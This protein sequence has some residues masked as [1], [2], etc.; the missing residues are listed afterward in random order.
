M[1]KNTDILRRL[2]KKNFNV[3]NSDEESLKDFMKAYEDEFEDGR[4]ESRFDKTTRG[5]EDIKYALGGV[6]S[7][8]ESLIEPWAKVDEAATKF[9]RTIGTTSAMMKKMRDQAIESVDKNKLAINYGLKAMDLIEAQEKYIKG[10]GRNV[11]LDENAQIIAGSISKII[12]DT[13]YELAAA[14]E[15]F[16]VDMEVT[17]EHVAGMYNEAAK[18]GISL[19]KYAQNVTSNIKLAQNYTFKNG[20]QGLE[21]MAKKATALKLDMSQVAAFADKVGTVEGSIESAARLQVLG[22]PFAQFANPLEML[23][24]SLTDMEGLTDR[25]IKMIGGL[26]SYDKI[27]GQVKVSPFN[28]L[29]IKAAA[30]AMGMSYDSLME[31]VNAQG[32]RKEIEN[33]IKRSAVASRFGDDMKELIMNS[34]TIN[35]EGKAVMSINGKPV[36]LDK[37]NEGQYEELVKET[38]NEAEDIKDIARLL[39]SHL[40]KRQGLRDQADNKL[41]KW[42]GGV[43][44]WISGVYSYLG[45]HGFL[46]SVIAA[47][48]VANTAINGVRGFRGLRSGKGGK[49]G[50]GLFSRLR[51]TRGANVPKGGPTAQAGEEVGNA[52]GKGQSFT[53]SNGKT[54]TIKD[55]KAFGKNG[56]VSGKSDQIMREFNKKGANKAVTKEIT[57]D[58]TKTAAT[59]AGK[60]ALT[61][62]RLMKAG[63][64]IGIAGAAGNMY[65]DYKVN[66]GDWEKGGKT[67][68]A[69]KVGSSAAEGL[70]WGLF[71]ASLA[72]SIAAGA[73]AGTTVG[74][75]GTAIGAA[76]GLITGAVIGGIKVA[77]ARREVALD[78]KLEQMGIKRK[79]DY[80]AHRLKMIHKGL[81]TGKISDSLRMKMEREGDFEI[82]AKIDEAR[83]R[84]EERNMK[85]NGILNGDIK[86]ASISVRSASF[87]GEAFNTIFGKN[88][89]S[90]AKAS[91]EGRETRGLA[92]KNAAKPAIEPILGP[93]PA[94]IKAVSEKGENPETVELLRKA[95]ENTKNNKSNNG[96]QENTGGKY[97]LK[98]S[99]TI[100]LEGA[101]GKQVDITDKLISDDK[102]IRQIAEK[103]GTGDLAKVDKQSMRNEKRS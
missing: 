85:K 88:N 8:I 16:G 73:G 7:A 68:A 71:G 51:G 58:A 39:R 35:K 54:Y 78:N 94:T 13:G 4:E 28:K 49:G 25:V 67:H 96:S 19:E 95:A 1:S 15:N 29:R 21:S 46:L 99:G 66:K 63:G 23:N 103:L 17:G 18:K 44:E 77:K 52:I 41:A 48:S 87:N 14:F 26:G 37:L 98:I 12:G 45:N 10:I 38:Q 33:Q 80:G 42:F 43:G 93:I 100:K 27:T 32:R 64:A 86:S 57:K 91:R 61:A 5:L 34:A 81:E 89:E 83:Q 102:F 50:G 90:K 55:G 75:I 60:G 2:L 69:M 53:A 70:G 20:I 31:S 3:D 84:A 6:K 30:E 82:L 56:G 97:E 62:G 79:G 9:A 65:T 59:Q 47:A 76:A 74:P 11:R 22:G 92:E 24:E 40:E 36:T 72:S 101:N